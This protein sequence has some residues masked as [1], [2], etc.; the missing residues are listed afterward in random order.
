[1]KGAPLDT[2]TGRIGKQE[3]YAENTK[4]AKILTNRHKNYPFHRVD[5]MGSLNIEESF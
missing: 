4:Y 2:N 3:K 1:V 5:E